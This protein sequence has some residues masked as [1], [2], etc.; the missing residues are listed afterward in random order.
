MAKPVVRNTGCWTVLRVKSFYSCSFLMHF[1]QIANHEYHPLLLRVPWHIS[2][3][4]HWTI[5]AFEI[6]SLVHCIFPVRK[7]VFRRRWVCIRWSKHWT[8]KCF[9]SSMETSRISSLV[10]TQSLKSFKLCSLKWSFSWILTSTPDDLWKFSAGMDSLIRL[11]RL[12][13]EGWVVSLSFRICPLLLWMAPNFFISGLFFGSDCFS[14][15]PDSVSLV[16][17]FTHDKSVP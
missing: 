15:T 12:D 10:M 17:G 7:S 3:V 6:L 16:H 1:V 4:P 8:L 2:R 14:T 13:L 9:Q 5:R 11:Q